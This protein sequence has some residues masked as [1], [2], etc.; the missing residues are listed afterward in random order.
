MTPLQEKILHALYQ[1]KAEGP[2]EKRLGICHNVERLVS[3]NG[4]LG[5][6]I[7]GELDQLFQTWPEKSVS[8]AYPVGNWTLTPSKLFWDY[9]DTGQSMWSGTRYGIARKALLQH[10]INELEKK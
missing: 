10:C 7:E 9:A 6:L 3:P 4:R 5:E 2:K 8:D 1:I